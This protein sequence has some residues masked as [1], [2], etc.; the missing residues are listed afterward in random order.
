[1]SDNP[2]L[3][4]HTLPPFE[5]IK[6]EHVAPAIQTI[7][8][9]NLKQLAQWLPEQINAP[10]WEGLVKPYEDLAQRLDAVLQAL[11]VLGDG[12]VS[13]AYWASHERTQTYLAALAHNPTLFGAFQRLY[14]QDFGT[15]LNATQRTALELIIRTLRLNGAGL[16]PQVQQRLTALELQLQVLYQ[17]F[18]EHMAAANGLWTRLLTAPDQLLGLADSD[19]GQLRRA[20]EDR[21][22]EGWLVTLDLP[23]YI[24]IMT[25]AQDRELREAC[26]LAFY[27][28]ASDQGPT[29]GQYDNGPVLEQIRT[30]RLERA[31][32]LGYPDHAQLAQATRM[33]DTCADVEQWLTDLAERIRPAA[34]AEVDGLREYARTCDG[35]DLQPWDYQYYQE[36]YRQAHYQV[37]EQA[38]SEYFPLETVLAGLGRLLERL[39]GLA[40]QERQDAPR[41]HGDVRVYEL[42]E[43]E[44]SLGH[45]YIDPYLRNGKVPGVWMKSMRD[46]HRWSDGRL[47]LPIARL[48]CDFNPP[49]GAMPTLLTMRN[50]RELLHEFGHAMHHLLTTVEHGS[51]AGIKGVSEDAV[52]FPSTL[53]EHWCRQGESLA[54]LSGHY[55]TGAAVP[56]T[57]LERIVAHGQY[58]AASEALEQI[59]FALG[60][61]ALHSSELTPAPVIER[62]IEQRLACLP[63]PAYVRPLNQFGHI[64]ATQDYAGG[65]YTYVWSAVMAADVFERFQAQGVL[66]TAT[67]TELRTLILAPG[68]TVAVAQMFAAFKGRGPDMGAYLTF[69]GIHN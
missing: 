23:R 50:V 12:P 60:D 5:D 59:K 49:L 35:V 41:Y 56:A 62:Q 66:D 18:S 19:Q 21:G 4:P 27:T 15:S 64:F 44:A 31:Q 6:P 20:A 53:F 22:Q 26:Y 2:L 34:L 67:A 13:E 46:R 1:M 3:Q 69:L 43:G 10:T 17:R 58:G 48:S 16:E 9:T 8:D 14:Q 47:Q 45:L 25:Y 38:V 30:L 32:L 37:S 57:L 54:L 65:Y 11:D 39:F 29:A 52:E 36:R 51:V 61:L 7:I 33:F 68:G 24:A 63:A 40:L 28:Q 55:Q 42:L